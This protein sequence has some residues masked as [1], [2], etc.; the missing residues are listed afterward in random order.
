MS[1]TAHPDYGDTESIKEWDLRLFVTD[2]TPR[3]VVAFKNLNRIC[4]EHLKDRCKIEVVDLLEHPELA[5]QE[6]IVAIPT[7]F[8]TSPKPRKVMVGDF[9]DEG[10]VLRALGFESIK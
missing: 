6:Q 9:S 7:L 1:T 5:R 4:N 2:W 8:K 10:R 3:C